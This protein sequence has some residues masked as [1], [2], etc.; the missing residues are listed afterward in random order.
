MYIRALGY[1][2]T[3]F[4]QMSLNMFYATLSSFKEFGLFEGH[5]GEKPL[6]NARVI[7]A[8]TKYKDIRI[9]WAFNYY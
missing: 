5:R 1:R 8:G 6:F 7:S 3:D 2:R 4:C 9:G